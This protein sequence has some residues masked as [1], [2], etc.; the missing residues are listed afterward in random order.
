VIWCG[1]GATGRD[2]GTADDPLIVEADLH[3]VQPDRLVIVHHE[4]IDVSFGVE[5]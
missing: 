2:R 5:G 1:F 3:A 4:V